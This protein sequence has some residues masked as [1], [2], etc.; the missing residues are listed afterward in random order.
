M[1]QKVYF[2]YPIGC[3]QPYRQYPGY[4][5]LKSILDKKIIEIQEEK[6]TPWSLLKA[7]L[8]KGLNGYRL[9]DKG[10]IQYPSYTLA[11]E[12]EALTRDITNLTRSINVIVSL[13]VDYYTI[14]I[15][16]SYIFMD[17][18][19]K[20]HVNSLPRHT[21]LYSN[22]NNN[23]KYSEM[24]EKIKVFIREEFPSHHYVNHKDL[25]DYKIEGGLI[26]GTEQV[27]NYSLFEYLFSNEFRYFSLSVLE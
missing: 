23:P 27:G 5:I 7:R 10:Y 11:L 4:K 26:Y 8:F 9:L 19:K 3:S 24:V 13:L 6:E 12:S 25:F 17:G 14:F 20:D 2:Y 16:D 15:E 1:I 22:L 18:L 21:I